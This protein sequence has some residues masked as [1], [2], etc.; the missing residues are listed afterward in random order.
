MNC[1]EEK[2]GSLRPI[3]DVSIYRR[4]QFKVPL[5]TVADGKFCD[6]FSNFQKK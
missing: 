1:F 6:I 5:T 4:K 2:C 3:Y